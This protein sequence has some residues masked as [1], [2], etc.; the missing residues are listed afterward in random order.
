LTRTT[1]AITSIKKVLDQARDALEQRQRSTGEVHQ[2]LATQFS[3]LSEEWAARLAALDSEN[4]AAQA[5]ILALRRPEHSL[6]Q[7][8]AGLIAQ[9]ERYVALAHKIIL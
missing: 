5:E 1:R 4:A 6:E 9:E 7:T 3:G 2:A 8:Q